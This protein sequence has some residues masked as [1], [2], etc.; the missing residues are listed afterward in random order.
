MR[1]KFIT[2]EGIDA[3]GKTTN[4]QHIKS[5]IEAHGFNV[6]TTR[7]PGGTPAAEKIRSLILSEKTVPKCEML[8]FAASRAQHVQELIEPALQ[9]GTIVISDRFAD[10][11]YAY[12]GEG[13]GYID[14]V[15]QL[16]H[17]VLKG[18]EPDF[19]LYFDLTLE[20]SV[21]RLKQRF[22]E[23]NHL[24]MEVLEFKQA[25]HRGYQKRFELHNHRMVWI[26]AMQSPEGVAK[27]V[28]TWVETVL[29]PRLMS[30]K[31]SHSV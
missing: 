24:D 13:R 11:T 25:V 9:S 28:S 22:G 5:L 6:I 4:I 16:E 20:E 1:G 21:K 19:T 31:E 12:Q 7:E 3:S 27:Q 17:F 30:E 8:L 14:D 29:I 10:S 18:F 2:L 23:I 26:D 15:L